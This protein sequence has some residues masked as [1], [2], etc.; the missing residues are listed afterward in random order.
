MPIGSGQRLDLDQSMVYHDRMID[1]SKLF[2]DYPVVAFDCETTGFDPVGGKIIELGAVKLGGS[3]LEYFSTLIDPG[4]PI[5]D[6]ASNVNKIYDPMV[7]GKPKFEE[8][9]DDFLKFCDGSICVA[10]NAPFDIGFL[11]VEL[12]GCKKPLPS[13]LV[14][15]DTLTLSEILL[16]KR[17]SHALQSLAWA[18]PDPEKYK[19]KHRAKDDAVLCLDLL[20]F[21]IDSL[22]VGRETSIYEILKLCASKVTF[23]DYD[24]GRTQLRIDQAYLPD[25]LRMPLVVLE[26]YT[27]NKTR[28]TETCFYYA[29]NVTKKR[30]IELIFKNANGK[31]IKVPLDD[32]LNV[33]KADLI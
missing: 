4:I 21:L 20:Q 11:A 16:P 3:E 8:V 28:T 30:T 26:Y 33:T 10:H 7:R 13:D 25:A 31:Y 2:C 22:P 23:R 29:A 17:T 15:I 24:I 5:P 19:T 9:A 12:Q 14:V 27:W 18:L 1:T 32:I 6:G